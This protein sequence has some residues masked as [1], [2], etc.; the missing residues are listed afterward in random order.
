V[1]VF[2][3]TV[4][5]H[6]GKCLQLK[7]VRTNQTRI[8]FCYQFNVL[9][10]I[11]NKIDTKRIQLHVRTLRF[12]W[13]DMYR[14]CSVSNFQCRT[15]AHPLSY[16]TI[17]SESVR[18]RSLYADCKKWTARVSQDNAKQ[19][20]QIPIAQ[21]LLR[22]NSVSLCGTKPISAEATAVGN[23][24]KQCSSEKPWPFAATWSSNSFYS[25]RRPRATGP[26][27]GMSNYITE[28]NTHAHRAEPTMKY[29]SSRSG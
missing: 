15:P 11:L 12:N 14:N 18:Y 8:L 29:S 23:V 21:V 6:T 13:S 2:V 3:N 22:S 27:V 16:T 17:S 1:L 9:L 20:L 28:R 5:R 26:V 4:H 7:C 25:D 10:A 24:W 19:V